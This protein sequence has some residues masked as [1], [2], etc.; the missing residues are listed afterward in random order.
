[1]EQSIMN[2]KMR[3]ANKHGANGQRLKQQS[4]QVVVDPVFFNAFLDQ[5]WM[6][7]GVGN[8][9]EATRVAIRAVRLQEND[10]SKTLFVECIKR[11][12][13]FQ[14]AE[15]I[16][17][18]LVRAW[19]DAW[20]TPLE[21]SGITKGL[22]N[23]DVDVGPAIKRA[24]AGWPQPQ[25][26]NDFL[27]SA[28][29]SKIIADPL[30]LALL[31][32]NKVADLE[33][34]RFLTSI[35]FCLLDLETK[36]Q[37]RGLKD[38]VA[39]QFYCALARQC[40]MNEYVFSLTEDERDNVQ[41]LQEQ[42]L[43]SLDKGAETSPASILILSAYVS[44][45]RLP[46]NI[47][48]KRSWRN[49]VAKLLEEQILEPAA[50]K[51]L[52]TSIP[53]IT[54][55][56]NATSVKVMKHYE[57]NPY[58]RWDKITATHPIL[59]DN[60]FTQQFPFSNFR[61]LGKGSD[62]DILIAG[63]GTG[64]HSIMFAKSFPNAR[65][66]AVDLSMPSLCYAKKKSRELGVDNIEY[67]QAD[68]LELGD[69]NKRFDIISSSGVLHHLA[70]PEQGWRNLLSLLQPDGCMHIGLYS[71]LARRNIVTAQRWVRERG[72]TPSRESIRVARQELIAAMPV[73][74]ALED[75]SRFNDFYSISGSRD[76]LFHSNELRYTIPMIRE[77]LGKHDLEFLGFSVGSETVNEFATQFSKQ[78]ES[79]LNIWERY[80]NQNPDAFKAMYEFWIQPKKTHM[81]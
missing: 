10:A 23:H 79:D 28:G 67:A 11:W 22:L 61:R 13:Y 43:D 41:K 2:R 7:L 54:P 48:L 65:I 60:D 33:M 5:G 45:D 57:E 55:I 52:R 1:M 12:A 18:I 36:A 19:R 75:V 32:Y 70:D 20:G 47:L 80:E 59:I 42:V 40:H 68:I 17:D 29:L 44:L 50:E 34:E 56:G 53:R 25:L 69:L 26:L 6:L 35:R 14:G 21:L 24:V 38:E 72:F 3:R 15:E 76:L 81:R 77:F 73:N 37:G 74:P 78:H 27:G 58:P 30:L 39:I 9:E 62:L 8:D 46:E 63:C 66:F 64:H 4:K 51:Q 49:P 16:K 71:E 31:D